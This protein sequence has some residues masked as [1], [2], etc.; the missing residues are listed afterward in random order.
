MSSFHLKIRE[1]PSEVSVF[2]GN[3]N[4]RLAQGR[5]RL[6]T[7]RIV[8]QRPHSSQI[9][10]IIG[11]PS[12]LSV[13]DLCAFLSPFIDVIKH[14][15]ILNSESHDRYIALLS[16]ITT[17]DATKFVETNHGTSF[18]TLTDIQPVRT[19]LVASVEFGE[20]SNKEDTL[21][22]ELVE[23]PVCCF[24][25]ERLDSSISSLIQVVCEHSYHVECLTQWGDS[26]CPVCRH[27]M[28]SCESNQTCCN[29]CQLTSDL[30]SCLICG[31]V[32]CGRNSSACALTHF[33]ETGHAFSLELTTQRVWSYLD[34]HFVHRLVADLEGKLV[35]VDPPKDS[36][37]K[38]ERVIV[39]YSEL[40]HTQLTTQREFYENELVVLSSR[41][42]EERQ[43]RLEMEEKLKQLDEEV[44]QQALKTKKL[45]QRNKELEKE[46]DSQKRKSSAMEKL[47]RSLVQ[48]QQQSVASHN[49]QIRDFK[50]TIIELK[51]ENRDLM[52]HLE[53]SETLGR[54]VSGEEASS[55]L[56]MITRK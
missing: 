40:L 3:P 56:M 49:S 51:N 37:S 42:D 1:D 9:A 16:F 10:C 23:L 46:L 27:C 32:N 55:G 52:K 44:E 18:P 43:Q 20:T 8:N 7:E 26:I 19:F 22:E 25:L 5:V 17:Q 24:C 6:F 15:R 29:G 45:R 34:D 48:R 54:E 47:N 14:V 39:E 53:M 50:N 28:V 12:S 13:I 21:S 38:M 30:W 2:S 11:I 4:V 33:K 41:L 36:E 35:S 31:Q